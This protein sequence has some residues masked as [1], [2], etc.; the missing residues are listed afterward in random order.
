M[1]QTLP[2]IL[3]MIGRAEKSIVLTT[4]AAFKAEPVM[5]A[6]QAAWKRGVELLILVEF[7]SPS[8]GQLTADAALAFPQAIVSSGCL[9]YWPMHLRPKNSKGLPAKVH[10]KC[11]VIDDAEALISSANLT[12]DA[13]LR[14]IEAGVRVASGGLPKKLAH[15]IRRLATTGMLR[16]FLPGASAPDEV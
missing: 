4:F 9:W 8:G 13:M 6:L 5:K 16:K 12:D 2:Q 3:E 15:N 10:A 14:N 7:K 11:L 1:R